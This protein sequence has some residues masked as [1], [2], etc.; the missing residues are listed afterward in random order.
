MPLPFPPD[1]LQ[2]QLD[3]IRT[4]EDLAR[5]PHI[6]A[7]VLRRRLI[8]LSQALAAHPYWAETGSTAARVAL[9]RQARAGVG[10]PAVKR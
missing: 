7:T 5:H 9:R 8:T 2:L 10:T 6:G 1:L 4:Y 3:A